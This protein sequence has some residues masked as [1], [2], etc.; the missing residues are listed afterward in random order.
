MNAEIV[1][2]SFPNDGT[3]PSDPKVCFSG[4]LQLC[5]VRLSAI[6]SSYLDF[7]YYV[8]WENPGTASASFAAFRLPS[9]RREEYRITH[10]KP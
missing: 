9:N 3:D 2:L 5:Q 7:G 6:A 8:S 4:T 1:H 10:V